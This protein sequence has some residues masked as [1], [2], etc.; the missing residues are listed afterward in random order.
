MDTEEPGLG[1]GV[2]DSHNVLPFPSCLPPFFT[3]ATILARVAFSL[4]G[5][6]S[7]CTGLAAST[8]ALSTLSKM[9]A[10]VVIKSKTQSQTTQFLPLLPG[11]PEVIFLTSLHRLIFKWGC[12]CIFLL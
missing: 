1:R 6:F 12:T 8:L 9:Q 10:N 4:L 11:Q 3:H 7:L 2:S 5:E